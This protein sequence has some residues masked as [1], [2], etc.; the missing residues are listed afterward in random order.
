MRSAS[1]RCYWGT[2]MAVRAASHHEPRNLCMPQT[3]R[4]EAGPSPEANCCDSQKYP[5]FCYP[6]PGG[7]K[8]LPFSPLVVTAEIGNDGEQAGPVGSPLSLWLSW[9]QTTLPSHASFLTTAF[10][11]GTQN[12]PMMTAPRF[13]SSEEQ[14]GVAKRAGQNTT[15]MGTPWSPAC[16]AVWSKPVASPHCALA[17]SSTCGLLPT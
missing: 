1:F 11:H 3:M 17:S 14:L 5:A 13:F 12:I 4:D 10:F 2:E 9:T 7:C 8:E 15:S 16:L 6:G